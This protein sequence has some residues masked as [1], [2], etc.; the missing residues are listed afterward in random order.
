MFVL[1]LTEVTEKSSFAVGLDYFRGLRWQ[2]MVLT[3][4]SQFQLLFYIYCISM[5]KYV[6]S[7]DLCRC[8]MY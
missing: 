6:H 4:K 5:Y 3:S 1:L 7:I 8:H 2:N